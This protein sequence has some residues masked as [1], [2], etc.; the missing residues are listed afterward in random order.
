[1]IGALAGNDGSQFFGIESELGP[2]YYILIVYCVVG[3]LS[4]YFLNTALMQSL[5]ADPIHKVDLI[6]SKLISCLLVEDTSVQGT[7]SVT[8]DSQPSLHGKDEDQEAA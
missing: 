1:L 2:A 4:Q 7:V 6:W 8:K 5:H 3:G